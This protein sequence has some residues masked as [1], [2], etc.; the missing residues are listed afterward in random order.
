MKTA[1]SRRQGV[2]AR[3]PAASLS[4]MAVLTLAAAT[5]GCGEAEKPP[6]LTSVT[7]ARAYSDVAIPLTL[8]TDDLRPALEVLVSE[9]R[10]EYDESTIHASLMA[11]RI[12]TKKP[13]SRRS[14]N[15]HQNTGRNG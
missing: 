6:K 10:A 8:S 4:V 13:C 3:A 2:P 7:P 9:Q 14:T 12:D 15:H 11:N 1:A 5:P